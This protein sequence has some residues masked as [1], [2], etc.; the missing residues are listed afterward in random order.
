MVLSGLY[1]G[2]DFGNVG[3]VLVSWLFVF[4]IWCYEYF[5]SFLCV[6]IEK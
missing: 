2:D 6:F 4:R 3:V 5:Y 1:R